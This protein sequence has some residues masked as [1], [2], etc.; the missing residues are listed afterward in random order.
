M[1]RG[2]AGLVVAA[3]AFALLAPALFV[4]GAA[5]V[6]LHV[7]PYPL[8]KAFGDHPTAE[9]ASLSNGARRSLFDAYRR[10]TD[11]VFLGDSLTEQGPWEEMFPEVRLANRGIGGERFENLLTRLDDVIALEPRAVF[12]MAGVNSA[13]IDTLEKAIADLAA[14]VSELRG[15][16]IEVVL[17]TT[18][19]P[20]GDRREYVIELNERLPDYA[21]TA[22]VPL[23]DL[24]PLQQVDG[25]RAELTYDGTHL[26]GDGYRNWEDVLRP[27]L[28]PYR[29]EETEVP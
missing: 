3:A 16:D 18:I 10:Q 5:T 15:H 12:I 28:A 7:W 29:R 8:L 25:L 22:G 17:Q 13:G 1:T 9:E 4:W 23:I 14:I 2:R 24:S 21:E 26:N 19:V 11:V 20:R 6:Q 27:Y